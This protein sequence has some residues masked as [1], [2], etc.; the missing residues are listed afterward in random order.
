MALAS[1]S[2]SGCF[3]MLTE[4]E[5]F[6]G[7]Q[8]VFLEVAPARSMNVLKRGDRLIISLRG[9][10]QQEDIQEVIDDRGCVT[11]PLINAIR[12]QGLTTADAEKLIEKTYIE[13]GYYNRINVSVVA[14]EDEYFVRGEVKRE[15]KYILSRDLTLVQAIA[16]AGGYTDFAKQSK[17]TVRRGSQILEFNLVKIE[18]GKDKAPLIEP[19]DVIV[20][21]RRW[22]FK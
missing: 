15:G 5:R 13:R 7:H 8:P 21:P 19:G 4:P 1:L 16:E 11:L 17:T 14:E 9:I 3:S 6:A 18:K 10:R 12:I 20:V 2:L 22:F